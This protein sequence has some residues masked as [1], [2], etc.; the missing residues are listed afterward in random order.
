MLP[1][2]LVTDGDCND[3]RPPIP[4]KSLGPSIKDGL[5]TDDLGPSTV[6]LI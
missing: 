4:H 6:Y 1:V 3:R 2:A 5:A